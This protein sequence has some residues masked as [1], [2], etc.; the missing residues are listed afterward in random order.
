MCWRLTMDREFV[1][2]R[3]G[4][5]T[6]TA[7]EYEAWLDEQ[8]EYNRDVML[9]QQELDDYDETDEGYGFYGSDDPYTEY[10]DY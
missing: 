3:E 10:E 4:F 5:D 9:A 2:S 7:A 1:D 8:D 6:S